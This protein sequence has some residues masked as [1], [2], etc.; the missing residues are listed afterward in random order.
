MGSLT[1][2]GISYAFIKD[3]RD[4]VTPGSSALFALTSDAVRDKVAEAFRGTQAELISTNLSAE[5]EA[6]LV[7]AFSDEA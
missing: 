2:V 4:K 6:A 7:K 5:Q 3:V 1:D